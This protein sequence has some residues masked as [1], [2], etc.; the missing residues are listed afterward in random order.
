MSYGKE[1]FRS[2]YKETMDSLKTIKNNYDDL[3]EEY[4]LE[5][6]RLNNII[7]KAIETIKD[8]GLV[9]AIKITNGE[10]ETL[11]S[12]KELLLDILKGE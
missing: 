12:S 2:K 6:E 7:D 11:L 10:E 1:I 5:I 9:V 3:D 4:Q 8:E